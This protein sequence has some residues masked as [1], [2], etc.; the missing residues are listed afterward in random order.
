MFGQ[1][2]VFFNVTA[3][4]LKLTKGKQFFLGKTYC[5]SDFHYKKV[6]ML[7][8]CQK[9]FKF[10]ELYPSPVVKMFEKYSSYMVIAI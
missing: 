5:I 4:N 3:G 9:V 2:C 10:R 1:V 7:K 8:N 6:G